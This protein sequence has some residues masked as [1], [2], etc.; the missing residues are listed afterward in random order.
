MLRS[1]WG[2]RGGENCPWDAGL[3]PCSPLPRGPVPRR[4]ASGS[5]GAQHGGRLG[6]VPARTSR[7]VFALN[8]FLITAV[9]LAACFDNLGVGD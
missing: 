3:E 9:S 8:R 2:G 7:R 6:E 4:E 1:A 5:P